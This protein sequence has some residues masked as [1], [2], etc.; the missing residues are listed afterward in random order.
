MARAR[1][2]QRLVADDLQS[3]LLVAQ[4]QPE[5]AFSI[6]HSACTTAKATGNERVRGALLRSMAEIRFKSGDL[7]EARELIETSLPIIEHHG[8][9]LSLQLSLDIYHRLTNGNIAGTAVHR[10]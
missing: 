6:L 5:A 3:R 2:D 1:S 9:Q 4:G 7:S 8:C 10:A